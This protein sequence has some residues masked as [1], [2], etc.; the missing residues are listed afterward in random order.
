VIAGAAAEIA[1]EIFA[2][3]AVGR[4]G[5]VL[6]QVERAHDHAGRAEAALQRVIVAKRLLHRVQRVAVG[7][8]LDG[9][10]RAALG[11]HRQQRARL[12]RLAIDMDDAGAALA[13]VAADMGAGEA[14][15]LAQELHQQG[16]PLDRRRNRL[17]VHGEAHRFCMEPSLVARRIRPAPPAGVSCAVGAG[18]RRLRCHKIRY[19]QPVTTLRCRS[20]TGS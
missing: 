11:L 13:G 8:V 3:F 15:R 14:E 10:D 9:L 17:A 12:D 18:S 4:V 7:D 5:V 20:R 19:I 2:D 16:A 1:F 6:H